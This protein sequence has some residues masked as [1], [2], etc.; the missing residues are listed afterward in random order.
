[1][2]PGHHHAAPRRPGHALYRRRE[3]RAG[4]ALGER[5]GTFQPGER[6]AYTCATAGGLWGGG[7][8]ANEAV[9]ARV[10]P[11]P[12]LIF[13][14]KKDRVG[15][16]QSVVEAARKF[17]E[18]QRKP[19]QI[20]QSAAAVCAPLMPRSSLQVRDTQRVTEGPSGRGSGERGSLRRVGVVLFEL[21]SKVIRGYLTPWLDSSQVRRVHG[22]GA[23]WA[24]PARRLGGWD[25]SP[26]CTDRL[27]RS[28]EVTF[29]GA[30]AGRWERRPEGLVR[31]DSGQPFQG[32]SGAFSP[33]SSPYAP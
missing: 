28:E 12:L 7:L 4:L 6:D 25:H 24:G 18:R 30:Q 33:T 3:E 15:S 9:A 19:G 23:D 10:P 13:R 21:V 20:P 1:V 14:W 2:R 31:S 26:E 32:G 29:T 11:D 8:S 16:G 17:P 22:G 5:C 27:G